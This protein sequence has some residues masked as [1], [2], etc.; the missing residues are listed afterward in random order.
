VAVVTTTEVLTVRP[1]GR[2]DPQ[3]TLMENG[4]DRAPADEP[5]RLPGVRDAASFDYKSD[6]FNNK[7]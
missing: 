4:C 5:S 7:V 3:T 1:G 2:D 6:P